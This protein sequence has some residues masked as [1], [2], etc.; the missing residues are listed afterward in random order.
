MRANSQRHFHVCVVCVCFCMHVL[1]CG[2]CAFARVFV[3]VLLHVCL[4]ALVYLCVLLRVRVLLHVCV[5]V[6]FCLCVCASA[7]VCGGGG[8]LVM[9]RSFME[10]DGPEFINLQERS[11]EASGADIRPVPVWAAEP[12]AGYR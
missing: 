1:V 8:H 10:T 12:A 3:C 7:C 11:E 9:E 6:C 2:L 4:C 5:C